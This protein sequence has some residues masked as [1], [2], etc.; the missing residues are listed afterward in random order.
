MAVG[1]EPGS[2]ESEVAGEGRAPSSI[3][4][5]VM[6]APIVAS[7]VVM[8]ETENVKHEQFRITDEIKVR[9]SLL[10]LSLALTV[11][12]LQAMTQEIIKT[13]RDIMS[14]NPMYR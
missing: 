11:Y 3:V 4:N 7:G 2:Q 5:D 9:M 1:G 6:G 13:I 8:V 12:L 10:I 14:V